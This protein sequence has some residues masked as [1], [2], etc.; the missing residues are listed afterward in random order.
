MCDLGERMTTQHED[1]LFRAADL[2][3]SGY[4]DVDEFCELMIRYCRGDEDAGFERK[5]SLS[6]LQSADIAGLERNLGIKVEVGIDGTR[7][8]S[9]VNVMGSADEDSGDEEEEE[10][11]EDLRDLSPEEQQRAVT[12]R[13]LYIMGMGTLLVSLLTPLQLESE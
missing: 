2:D 6:V 8:I 10:M 1:D 5:P 4:I 11:P 7:K 9:T 3:R 12:M 13:S